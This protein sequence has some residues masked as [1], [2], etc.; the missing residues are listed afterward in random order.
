L[1]ARYPELVASV[2]DGKYSTFFGSA[3]RDGHE[4][5]QKMPVVRTAM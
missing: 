2:A 1:H 3:D 4:G 5:R